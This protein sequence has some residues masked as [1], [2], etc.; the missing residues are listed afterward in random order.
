VRRII[1]LERFFDAPLDDVWELWTTKEGI[2]SWWGPEGFE[3]RVETLEL[4]EGGALV[5]VM[6]A[7]AAEQIAAMKQANLPLSARLTARYSLVEPKR[8]V[9]WQ[10]LADFIPGVEPYEAATRVELSQQGDG[11]VHMRLLIEAMHDEHYTTLAKLGWESELDKL[12]QAL[13]R[14]K[15]TP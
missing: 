6:T 3:V 2:E 10:N 7:V 11:S 12:K 4:R 9:A 5:Y 15:G 14:R 13:E 1:T 8:A